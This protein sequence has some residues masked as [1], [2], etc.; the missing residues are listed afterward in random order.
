MDLKNVTEVRSG[1]SGLWYGGKDGM[2]GWCKL[3]IKR[4]ALLVAIQ[5]FGAKKWVFSICL[6]SSRSLVC[7]MWVF[8]NLF[9]ELDWIPA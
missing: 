2:N 9:I 3:H 8:N 4:H 5:D 1:S 7:N 6:E